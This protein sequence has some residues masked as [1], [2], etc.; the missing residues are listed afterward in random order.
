MP[1]FFQGM[2]YVS[3]GYQS[4]GIIQRINPM[5]TKTTT[6][7]IRRC[8]FCAVPDIEGKLIELS[9]WP[10]L[11]I[12]MDNNLLAASSSHFDKV[13]DRL[14]K[15]G[16]ADFNQGLDSRLLT[17]YHAR[18]LSEIKKPTIRLALD[19]MDYEESWVNAFNALRNAGIAKGNIRSYALI[20]FDSDPGEARE[21]CKFIS[22]FGIKAL[23]QWF[24]ELDAME[25]NIVTVDQ[26]ALGWTDSDRKGIMQYY[27][28]RG[29][30]RGYHPVSDK[31]DILFD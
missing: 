7:C 16:W 2:D 11:P 25:R 21:R 30:N 27:Y 5:A 17:E 12:V 13:I 4:D 15:W 22:S 14:V 28:Q 18:R 23:P 6:G 9:D 3:I 8:E 10:D 29:K 26:K 24:H 1:D 31:E 19:S 20:G